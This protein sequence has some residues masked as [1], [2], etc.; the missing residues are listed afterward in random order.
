M[1]KMKT[2]IINIYII[3]LKRKDDKFFIIVHSHTVRLFKL[4]WSAVQKMLIR[5]I[6]TIIF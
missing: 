1:N 2:Y 6:I 5:S 3:N 4:L